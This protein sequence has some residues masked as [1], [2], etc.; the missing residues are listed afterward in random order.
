MGEDEYPIVELEAD[1]PH[2]I[3]K[4]GLYDFRMPVGSTGIVFVAALS[5]VLREYGPEFSALVQQAAMRR[6]GS[7]LAW[8]GIIQGDTFAFLRQAAQLSQDDLADQ[9]G[10]PVA[11]LQAWEAGTVPIPREYWDS[12][13][14]QV[15]ALDGRSPPAGPALPVPPLGLR[16]RTV[17]VFPAI[18]TPVTPEQPPLPICC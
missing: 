10:V 13:A 18:P 12:L 8:W 1:S 9:L 14:T 5:G 11:T 6:A 2:A 17:R 7:T 4:V 16:A 15:C 3:G